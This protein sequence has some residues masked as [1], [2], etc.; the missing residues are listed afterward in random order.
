M[1]DGIDYAINSGKSTTEL[2]S[3]FTKPYGTPSDYL[4][5]DRLYRCED[6]IFEDMDSNERDRLFGTPVATVYDSISS[7]KQP[8]VAELLGKDGIFS[9]T[10]LDSYYQAMLVRWE[11]ELLQ[12]IIPANLSTLRSVT[13]KESGGCSYDER[14]WKDITDLKNL[15]G[16][17]TDEK[18]SIFTRIKGA[19]KANDWAKTSE[20][21]LA[22]K[23]AMNELR[24]KYKTYCENQI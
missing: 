17:D 14:L 4:L 11:M 22:M 16:K 19:V 13:R 24:S 8:D 20:Y 18:Q 15:L 12:K 9:P 10:L 2:E 3:E 7:L 5:A 6:D 21:Q 1:L 23:N